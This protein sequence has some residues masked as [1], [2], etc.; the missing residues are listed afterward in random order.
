MLLY[1]LQKQLHDVI[2]K[3]GWFGPVTAYCGVVE[4]QKRGLLHAHLIYTLDG[5]HHPDTPEKVDEIVHAYLPDPEKVL[6]PIS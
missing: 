4:S 3:E 2:F 5:P 6:M 1:S